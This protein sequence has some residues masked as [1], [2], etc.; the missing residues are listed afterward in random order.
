MREKSRCALGATRGLDERRP[1]QTRTPPFG[2]RYNKRFRRSGLELLHNLLLRANSD[3]RKCFTNSILTYLFQLRIQTNF[4][5]KHRYTF[6]FVYKI[7]VC[8]KYKLDN[9]KSRLCRSLA[10]IVLR[11]GLEIPSIKGLYARGFGIQ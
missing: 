2:G 9:K 10:T 5:Y 4:H 11:T 3:K 8:V 1:F 7:T 6:T